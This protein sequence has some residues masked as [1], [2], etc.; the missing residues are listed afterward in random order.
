MQ[1][2]KTFL[3][4]FQEWS[5]QT[6]V[7]GPVILLVGFVMLLCGLSLCALSW[8]LAN[9]DRNNS[10]FIGDGVRGQN[11][12]TSQYYYGGTDRCTS[13]V[14]NAIRTNTKQIITSITN[15]FKD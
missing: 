8:K 15:D 1:K 5:T 6:K 4:V 3:A 9:E 14:S 12:N 11:N 10:I 2:I 7:L 13:Q